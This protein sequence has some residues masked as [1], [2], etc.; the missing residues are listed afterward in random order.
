MNVAAL[1]FLLIG[2]AVMMY[3]IQLNRSHKVKPWDHPMFSPPA[4]IIGAGAI[5][6]LAS[7]IALLTG[8]TKSNFKYVNEEGRDYL[9]YD[10]YEDPDEEEHYEGEDV[11]NSSGQDYGIDD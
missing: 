3:G 1:V 5:T 2:L 7:F 11:E 9:G 8:I 6:A 10:K 4:L